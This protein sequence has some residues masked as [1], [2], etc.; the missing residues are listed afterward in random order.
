MQRMKR[1]AAKPELYPR[2]PVDDGAS[3]DMDGKPLSRGQVVRRL[4]YLSPALG[5]LVPA[6]IGVVV[7]IYQRTEWGPIMV[8]FRGDARMDCAGLFTSAADLLKATTR[9]VELR[10]VRDAREKATVSEPTAD[11]SG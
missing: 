7:D 4:E 1:V 10:W 2:L 6:R 3:F 5:V 11:T 8:D 9:T